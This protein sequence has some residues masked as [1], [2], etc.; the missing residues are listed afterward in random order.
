[1]T[2][3]SHRTAR[4]AAVAFHDLA[5]A[6]ADFGA[7]VLAGLGA[8]PKTLPCKFFYD[9]RGS[10]LFQEICRLPEYYPTRTEMA[11]MGACA[12]DIGACAGPECVVVEYG[13]GSVDKA[14]LLLRALDRPRA[15]VAVDI[16]REHL[17][18]AAET[19]ADE[20][21]EVAVHAVCADFTR[22]FGLPPEVDGA[23]RLAFFP[24]ST[25]GNFSPAEARDFL[26]AIAD[27]VGDGGGLLIGID[28]KKDTA[29]LDAAYDDARGVTAAFNLNL[30]SRIN[31]ELGGT[32]ALDAFRHEAGYNPAE[33][34]V[35]MHLVSL[36]DQ[37]AEVHGRTF[38]FAAGETVHTE[39][40]YKYTVAEFQDL[41]RGAGFTAEDAWTDPDDL[42]SI[43][44]LRRVAG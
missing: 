13:I 21:P 35:E 2:P 44:C 10:A 31:R 36:A 6:P 16:S 8:E 20:F 18:A 34:R 7:E 11:L 12:A 32:F 26:A 3:E 4:P 30:L 43:H 22:P 19:L 25:L 14:R 41:A 5:P 23:R 24:G 29:V 42:F 40:S 27:L 37:T 9:Q 17:L 33:G 15:Y 28:L 39:N 38:A 1:M